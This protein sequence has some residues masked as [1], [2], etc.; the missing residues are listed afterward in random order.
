M[1]ANAEPKYP[2]NPTRLSAADNARINLRL[3]FFLALWGCLSWCM[4]DADPGDLLASDC[5]EDDTG[6][7]GC[8]REA[9]CSNQNTP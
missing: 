9:R 5:L 1:P 2:R 6:G 3:F 4:V 7:C 8:P